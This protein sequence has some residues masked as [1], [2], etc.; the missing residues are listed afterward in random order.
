[1]ALLILT[2]YGYVKSSSWYITYRVESSDVVTA[3]LKLPFDLK[4]WYLILI[5]SPIALL[6]IYWGRDL[7]HTVAHELKQLFSTFAPTS[8]LPTNG[9]G[10]VEMIPPV[11]LIPIIILVLLIVFL[12]PPAYRIVRDGPGGYP[13]PHPTPVVTSGETVALR[14]TPDGP[15]R[16]SANQ[17][18][19]IGVTI[20][21]E[22]QYVDDEPVLLQRGE[23]Y[24]ISTRLQPGAFDVAAEYLKP[25]EDILSASGPV[26][27]NWIIA[28]KL[29]R[30]GAQQ[31]AF[32]TEIFDQNRQKRLGQRSLIA[33]IEVENPIGLPSWLVYLM[34]FVGLAALIPIG[35]FISAEISNRLK[36][37]REQKRKDEEEARQLGK[38]GR[39]NDEVGY[40]RSKKQQP[41]GKAK[42]KKKR[43]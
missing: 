9:G 5:A 31:I 12:V 35:N 8:S 38:E 15:N 13:T 41:G 30:L 21:L 20:S 19:P 14:L 36:E 39:K 16:I 10:L 1:V 34:P 7:L 26:K 40:Y 32:D 33:T 29:D 23:Q 18:V 42:P 11:L 27:W 37:K 4:W 24:L 3:G 22:N 6:L 28:P 25:R 2:V 17:Q 43:R